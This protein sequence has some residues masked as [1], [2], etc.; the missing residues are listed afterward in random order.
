[1]RVVLQ[2]VTEA[3]ASSEGQETSSIGSGLLLLIG[4]GKSDNQETSGEMAKK[5]R[6]LRVFEDEDGK[7]N[8]DIIQ[9]AGEVLS[10]PQFTLLGE[11]KKGNR[12][13]FDAA[14]APAEAKAL[15]K[16]F[17]DELNSRGIKVFE[18]M[19]GKHMSVSLIND[20]PV[21]FILEGTF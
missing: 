7:M 2:R 10:V 3:S 12:P 5:I 16:Y 6:N 14:A 15:W 13:G 8:L 20:G 18:G 9:A 1:M 21:T 17:N 4:I 19:F 11:T